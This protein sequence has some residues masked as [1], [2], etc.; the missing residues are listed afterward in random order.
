MHRCGMGLSPLFSSSDRI[1]L[2]FFR[3]LNAVSHS[4]ASSSCSTQLLS[5]QTR[6]EQDMALRTRKVRRGGRDE[7]SEKDSEE[8]RKRMH[9]VRRSMGTRGQG[10]GR[11]GG[12]RKGSSA[13][14]HVGALVRM[15]PAHLEAMAYVSTGHCLART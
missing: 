13:H 10:R 6:T 12:R 4:S 14:G 8:R 7:E 1:S 11:G 9:R 15:A 3:R 5:A 2:A